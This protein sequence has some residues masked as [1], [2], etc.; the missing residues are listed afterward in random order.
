[1]KRLFDII[2]SFFSLLILLPLFLLIAILIKLDSAGPV[3]FIQKR[4]GKNFK[5]FSLYKFRTM[6]VDA[7]QRGP[8]ITSAGDSRITKIG[9]FLRKTKFDEL[10]QIINVLKGDMSV[11]GPRP[12]VLKYV[13]MFKDDYKNILKVKPGI[14][15]YAAIEFRDEECVLKKFKDPEGGYIK[16]V[17]PLKIK[18]YNRYVNERSLSTDMKLIFLTLWK[19]VKG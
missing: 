12:E 18:L 9:R 10:P 11:V 7:S 6:V 19:I 14:T 15:D 4:V 17:L 8:Q 3:F 1:M 13:E 16:E 5:L 2:S